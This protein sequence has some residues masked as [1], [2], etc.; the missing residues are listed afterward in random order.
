MKTDGNDKETPLH[1][2][3]LRS[4]SQWY[5]R[6]EKEK[7]HHSLRESVI[8]YL[9]VAKAVVLKLWAETLGGHISHILHI[10]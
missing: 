5:V 1:L 4:P 9:E 7:L 2:M 10:R 6:S 8:C 3:P